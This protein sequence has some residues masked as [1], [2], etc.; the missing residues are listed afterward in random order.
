MPFVREGAQEHADRFGRLQ[1]V[2][3]DNGIISGQFNR[4]LESNLKHL[5]LESVMSHFHIQQRATKYT[6]IIQTEF[7]PV[8][9]KRTRTVPL[10]CV[11]F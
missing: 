10:S 7:E 2:P 6:S 8:R 1:I 11:F 4:G 3:V 9:N 5:Q